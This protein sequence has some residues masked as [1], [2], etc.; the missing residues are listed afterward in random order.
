MRV[1]DGEKPS[2]VYMRAKAAVEKAGFNPKYYLHDISTLDMH[3]SD[4]E[5]SMRVILDNG[6]VKSLT[7]ADPLFRTLLVDSKQNQRSWLAMP[8]EAKE[9]FGRVR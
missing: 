2:D 1:Q 8:A 4:L 5:Q 9:L 6:N 7:D 3:A